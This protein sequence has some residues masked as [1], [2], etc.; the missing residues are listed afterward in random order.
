MVVCNII[1][2]IGAILVDRKLSRNLVTLTDRRF[3]NSPVIS[4]ISDW[5]HSMVIHHV[6]CSELNADYESDL[7][8]LCP[9]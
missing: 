2:L 4:R 1:C 5:V 3:Q 7:R 6:S 9:L 8:Q